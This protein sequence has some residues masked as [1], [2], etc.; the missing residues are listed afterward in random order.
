[1]GLWGR[2]E[3]GGVT[4]DP[5]AGNQLSIRNVRVRACVLTGVLGMKPHGIEK[6]YFD[7]VD[8]GYRRLKEKGCITTCSDSGG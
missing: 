2:E 7:N 5:G 3:V 4:E 1:M 6:N 8:Y